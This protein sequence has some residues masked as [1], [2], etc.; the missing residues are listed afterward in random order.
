MQSKKQN[1][2][3]NESIPSFYLWLCSLDDQSIDL[4]TVLIQYINRF[5][6]L[7]PESPD[8]P[9]EISYIVAKL[10]ILNESKDKFNS[11]IR[12]ELD[13]YIQSL[14]NSLAIHRMRLDM[15]KGGD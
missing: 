7:R 15:L 3:S 4:E 6:L 10:K 5:G 2:K 13:S 1:Q 8:E 11:N 9:S 12:E 14:L